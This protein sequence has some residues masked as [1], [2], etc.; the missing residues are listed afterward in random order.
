MSRSSVASG[1]HVR[2]LERR[3]RQVARRVAR[4]REQL[5][6][7]LSERDDIADALLG[8]GLSLAQTGRAVGGLC[9]ERTRRAV[10][11]RRERRQ[12]EAMAAVG[13]A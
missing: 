3:G 8:A 7:A 11:A 13:A 5:A 1:S 2:D 4:L 6:D 9:K 10:A 12:A